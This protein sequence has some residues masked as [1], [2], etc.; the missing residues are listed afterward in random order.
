MLNIAVGERTEISLN[1][2]IDDGMT[3]SASNVIKLIQVHQSTYPSGIVRAQLDHTDVGTK[4]RQENR[5]LY[6]SLVFN[7]HGLLKSQSTHNLLLVGNRAVQV[8]RKQFP[9]RP[10]ATKTIHRSQGDTETK[11]VL[12][13]ETKRAI[14]HIHY[15][16]LSCV[17][18]IEGLHITNL[19]KGKISVSPAVEKEMLRLRGEGKLKLCLSPIYTTPESSIKLSFLNA[20]SLHKHV[21]LHNRQ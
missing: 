13:F 17:T 10:A 18:A 3:N 19:C 7:L 20:C 8:V 15:V 1:T 6:V 2:R 9:L 14:P 4:T 12:N 5:H 11:I 21:L 16:G